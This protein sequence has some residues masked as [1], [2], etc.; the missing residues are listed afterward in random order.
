MSLQDELKEQEINNFLEM[1]K[2]LQ[3]DIYYF[4]R[5]IKINQEKIRNNNKQIYQMCNHDWKNEIISSEPCGNKW[6]RCTKC[7]LYFEYG[8]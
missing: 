4:E 6:E 5:L 1:N 3:N 2:T 7:R 8:Y